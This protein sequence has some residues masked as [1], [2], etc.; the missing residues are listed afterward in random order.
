MKTRKEW[1]HGRRFVTEVFDNGGGG[2]SKPEYVIDISGYDLEQNPDIP[3]TN[4]PTS[5]IGNISFIVKNEF[6]NSNMGI[7]QKYYS[8]GHLIATDNTTK[9]LSAIQIDF[10]TTAYKL[11][12]TWQPN[13]PNVLHTARY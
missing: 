10:V 1:F 6:T 3:V 13:T 2:G 4:F 11:S 12:F 7:S 8:V 9:K 5:D